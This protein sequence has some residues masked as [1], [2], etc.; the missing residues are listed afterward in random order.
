[1]F[2]L[3][4]SVSA[5]AET[6]LFSFRVSAN[7][8]QTGWQSAAVKNDWEQR[9]YITCTSGNIY[10]GMNVRLYGGTYS[11]RYTGTMT[12]SSSCHSGTVPYSMRTGVPGA[13]YVLKCQNGGTYATVSGRWTP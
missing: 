4:V 12:L 13:E 2:V 6:K 1:M 5:L 9:A 11:A 7:Q 10:P 8:T 3:G